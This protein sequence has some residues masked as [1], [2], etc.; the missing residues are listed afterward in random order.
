[1]CGREL[2]NMLYIGR[3]SRLKLPGR[4]PIGRL[5][6]R[7]MDVVKADMKLVGVREEDAWGGIWR[8]GPQKETEKTECKVDNSNQSIL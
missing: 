1:M 6:G 3:M 7:Y 5:K 8:Q 4:S 2:V